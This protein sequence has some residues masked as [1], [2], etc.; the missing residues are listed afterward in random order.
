MRR[1]SAPVIGLARA[2]AACRRGARRRRRQSGI[3]ARYDSLALPAW[4]FT[5][6][7]AVRSL[8]LFAV[9]SPVVMLVPAGVVLWITS[10]L[11]AMKGAAD[12]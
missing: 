7:R 10:N 3:A 8:F 1:T 2:L 12:V 11:V 9:T 6:T 4:S 5:H